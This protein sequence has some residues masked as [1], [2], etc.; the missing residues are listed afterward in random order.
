LALI[1]LVKS[2]GRRLV[3]PLLGYPGAQLT[4]S[5]LKQNEFNPVLHASTM[6]KIAARFA[7]DAVFFM[8]DL[9]LEAGALGL[10][11]RYPLYESP[12][13]EKHPVKEASDLDRLRVVDPLDDA[14]LVAYIKTMELMK[15]S[16]SVPCA[17]YVAGPFTLAG[18][19]MGASDIAMATITDP[20]LVHQTVKFAQSICIR[21]SHA[22]AETGADMI[23]VL[24]PT[25]TFLSPRS[26]ATFCGMYVR[27][28][29]EAAGM[30]EM[31]IL[32]ICGDTKHLLREM[33][34]TG[35]HGLSLDAPIDLR[36][37]ADVVDPDVVLIGNV[38]PVGVMLNGDA[39]QVA[40]A[41]RK[42]LDSMSDVENFI[43]STGCDLPYETPHE[44]IDAFM[45]EGRR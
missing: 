10:P 9:S 19:L 31:M 3:A 23:V 38:D 45:D 5:S 18:L 26:F 29:I 36:A 41:V 24:E 4:N 11:V 25:A 42:L 14:R 7:P 8:M 22:L 34:A 15:R 30:A 33:C 40:D 21:Y 16:I 39:D 37:A 43:L 13:V 17:A 32:H 44:N 2:S 1:E 28:I 27:E 20:K 12:S 35:A 6:E